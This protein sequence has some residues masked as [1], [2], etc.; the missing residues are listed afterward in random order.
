MNSMALD[1][2]TGEV[3]DPF[4]G[5]TD[6]ADRVLRAT[7]PAT[8]SE[9]PLRALRVAQFAARFEMRPDAILL[10]LLGHQDL[11]E[12]PAERIWWELHKL[13]LKGVRPSFGLTTLRDG[14][15]L[16]Y[17]PEL[18]ALI[19]C[20]QDP[21][22]HPEGDVFTH[23]LLAIDTASSLRR[24]DELHDLALM[25]GVLCHDFGKPLT[26][27][28]DGSHIRS[29][30]HEAAGDAPTRAFLKHIGAPPSLVEM[31]VLLVQHHL[32][33]VHYRTA[34]DAAY[35]R[36][37]RK[38][39]THGVTLD[40]LHTVARA[41]HLGRTTDDAVAG[42][43]PDGDRFLE[44]SRALHVELAAPKDIV[45]GR[46]LIARGMTPGPSFGPILAQCR[47]I[48]MDTGFTDPEIILT[49]ILNI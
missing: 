49:L 38:L 16:R 21:L 32:A 28:T 11:S 41:D 13:L 6:L 33:P 5:R 4:N 47:D 40:L 19:R 27:A 29:R 8:F 18:D 35:R 14:H 46:H 22:W 34:S 42:H 15:L 39:G 7:D 31:V 25:L 12:L 10:D 17:F 23:T 20:P 48:Q 1:P 37:A 24:G 3:L 2:L 43:F 9:D 30:G 36:L 44:R 26:T 45:L